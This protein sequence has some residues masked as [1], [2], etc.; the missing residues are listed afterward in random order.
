MKR[1]DVP[2]DQ[3]DFEVE[4]RALLQLLDFDS[5]RFGVDE[6]CAAFV[7]NQPVGDNLLTTPMEGLYCDC[8]RF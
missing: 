5:V 4:Y 7:D 8:L 3:V 6:D 2:P 1:S